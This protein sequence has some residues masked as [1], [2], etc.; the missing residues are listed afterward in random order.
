MIVATF[1][2]KGSKYG[3][4]DYLAVTLLCAGA[5]GYSWGSGQGSGGQNE[6]S[7]TWIALLLVSVCCDAFT[8]NIQQ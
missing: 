5:A 4:L 2:Q 3:A 7:L 1:L 6:N 8:P